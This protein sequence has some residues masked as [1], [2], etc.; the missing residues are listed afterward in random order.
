MRDR[1]NPAYRVAMVV[2]LVVALSATLVLGSGCSLLESEPEF[3]T[4][5]D[6]GG[7]Y[8]FLVPQGWQAVADSALLAVY[9]SEEL[10]AEDEA[11]DVLS[12]VVLSGDAV[13][14]AP[15]SR[16]LTDFVSARSESREWAEATIS[17]PT[18]TTVGGR[19]AVSIDV[20]ATDSTGVAF[21][22]R[23][24]QVRT[25]GIDYVIVGVMPGP[26][27]EQAGTELD[28]ITERWYWHV[29]DDASAEDTA[30]PTE[31]EVAE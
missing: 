19:P 16:M 13:E 28:G 24:Y 21:T 29:P 17:E 31:E 25:A 10:P 22:A 4:V 7:R 14:E 5:T 18:S 2:A 23:F 11:L 27:F 3:D 20:A 26:D 30:T 12:V 6:Y 8:H 1:K 9:A 15:E